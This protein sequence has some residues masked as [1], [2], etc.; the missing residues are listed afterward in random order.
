M[1]APIGFQ[2]G[3]LLWHSDCNSLEE[4]QPGIYELQG[5]RSNQTVTVSRVLD[6][7][8]VGPT[9]KAEDFPPQKLHAITIAMTKQS[10]YCVH[11][12]Q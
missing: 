1:C 8:H 12:G 9:N 10:T 11:Y 7:M 5:K 6:Y 4:A 3:F 2:K